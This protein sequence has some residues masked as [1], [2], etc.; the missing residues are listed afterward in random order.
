MI[1]L[2]LSDTTLA[3]SVYQALGQAFGLSRFQIATTAFVL[4]F[5]AVPFLLLTRRTWA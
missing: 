3:V 4:L 5:A 2:I 1:R